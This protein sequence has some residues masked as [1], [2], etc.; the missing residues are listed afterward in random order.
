LQV[1][2]RVKSGAWR[3]LLSAIAMLLDVGCWLLDVP[4][5]G[6]RK[7]R[8][9]NNQHPS[10]N[11]QWAQRET[12][13]MTCEGAWRLH[14]CDH[15][16]RIFLPDPWR[17]RSSIR[18]YLYTKHY[19]ERYEWIC[20]IGPLARQHGC[21]G[22]RMR[23]TPCCLCSGSGPSDGLRCAASCIR[24]SSAP[25]LSGSGAG[26]A[27]RPAGSD[28]SSAAPPSGGHPASARGRLCLG[29]RVLVLGRWGL[30]LD[31]GQVCDPAPSACRMGWAALGQARARLRVGG[32][33]LAVKRSG[34]SV[35]LY[36]QTKLS[37][38]QKMG[39]SGLY[40]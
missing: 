27:A 32:R 25:G 33:I 3:P 1:K 8:T 7:H 18:V 31:G 35:P 13:V 40:T 30:G 15:I 6:Q 12:C 37:K 24:R 28:S 20:V 23:R 21:P 36:W 5:A 39:C 11:I 29:A 2:A 19:Y 14:P 10:S 34:D 16:S 9:S 26:S 22:K 38:C 17:V 4:R